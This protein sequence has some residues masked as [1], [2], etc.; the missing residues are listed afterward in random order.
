MSLS[1]AIGFKVTKMKKLSEV[2]RFL[3]TII[4]LRKASEIPVTSRYNII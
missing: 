1:W 3:L 4:T 2:F